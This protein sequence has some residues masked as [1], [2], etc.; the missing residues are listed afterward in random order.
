MGGKKYGGGSKVGRRRI[1]GRRRGKGESEGGMECGGGIETGENEETEC[2]MRMCGVGV[3]RKAAKGCGE[4]L[5]VG[6][7]DNTII[8][9]KRGNWGGEMCSRRKGDE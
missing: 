2:S 1:N 5:E 9:T 6:E 7:K 4:W 3:S 8:W